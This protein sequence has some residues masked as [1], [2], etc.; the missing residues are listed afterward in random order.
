MDMKKGYKVYPDRNNVPEPVKVVK[1]AAGFHDM[2]LMLVEYVKP[3]GGEVVSIQLTGK[4]GRN[5][6]MEVTIKFMAV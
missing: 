3:W 2:H 6:G 4:D 5:R 1:K